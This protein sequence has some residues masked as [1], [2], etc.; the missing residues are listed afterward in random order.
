MKPRLRSSLYIAS[1]AALALSTATIQAAVVVTTDSNATEGFF[2]PTTGDLLETSVA[3]STESGWD[4]GN[5]ASTSF[6][7]DG[8]YGRLFSEASTVDGAW[9]KGGTPFITYNLDVSSTPLGYDLTKIVSIAGW[10]DAGLGNQNLQVEV[11]TVGSA[12]F[13]ILA[14]GSNNDFGTTLGGTSIVTMQD[15][16]PGAVIASGVDAIRFTSLDSG[17]T[18]NNAVFREFD[19]IAVPEPSAALLLGFAGVG[20][21]LRRRR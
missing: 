1:F 14:T 8:S 19:V 17:G 12:S 18:N 9:D 13:T 4:S 16:T 11:S 6:L 10:Q 5:S 7:N 21:L 3:S 2:I 15:A 20:L